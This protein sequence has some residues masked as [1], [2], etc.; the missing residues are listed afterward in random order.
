MG[1]FE[2]DRIRRKN[3]AHNEAFDLYQGLITTGCNN[4]DVMLYVNS[5][6]QTAEN[7]YRIEVLNAIISIVRGVENAKGT[8]TSNS[9]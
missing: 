9:I 2:D 8:P 3:R 5:A 6:L 1:F 7:P 4:D